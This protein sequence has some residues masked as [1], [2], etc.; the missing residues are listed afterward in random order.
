MKEVCVVL[1]TY[2]G[3]KYLDEQIRSLLNQKNVSLTLLVRDDG[4]KDKTRDILYAWAERE[5]KVQILEKNFG[6]NFGV[7]KSFVYLISCA[8]DLF[9]KI[10]YFF[11]CDQDDVWLETKCCRAVDRM[12]KY[13]DEPALY[14]SRKKLVDGYLQPLNHIDII[15]LHDNFWDFFDRSNAFGCTMCLTRSLLEIIKDD[16]FYKQCFMHD[17]Y[18]YRLSLAAGFPIVYDDSETILYRQHGANVSGAAKRNAFRGIKRLF[19]KDRHH[20]VREMSDYLLQTHGSLL[21]SNNAKIMILFSTS[22]NSMKNKFHLIS[23]YHKQKNR[24]LKEKM[25]FDISIVLN[26][27]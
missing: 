14:F 2:N 11:F 25:L 15:R 12:H 20:V 5:P 17:N 27:Y 21:D 18:I 16:P 10:E 4:S 22:P 23:K 19:N 1:S 13:K 6:T 9:P 26:Y 24:S 8:Y 7:A 3:E